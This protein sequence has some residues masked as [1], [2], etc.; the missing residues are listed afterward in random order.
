MEN[1]LRP[2]SIVVENCKGIEGG[3]LRFQK[4]PPGK[5]Q[6]IKLISENGHGKTSF[7]LAIDGLFS[8]GFHPEL[9]RDGAEKFRAA[10]ILSD[11]TELERT[12]TRKGH[13]PKVTRPE[14]AELPKGMGIETYF[15]SLASG[16]GFDPIQFITKKDKRQE[17]LTKVMPMDF[18]EAEVVAAG[19][20][21]LKLL[22]PPN[23]PAVKGLDINGI[24]ALI[25]DL[26]TK[27]GNIGSR[28]DEKASSVET[29]RKSLLRVDQ[30][31][32][33][34]DWKKELAL[35][36]A[37]KAAIEKEERED[38][39][40]IENQIKG[41]RNRLETIIRALDD[42]AQS[43]FAALLK[44]AREGAREDDIEGGL[45][46]KLADAM[47]MLSTN[48]RVLADTLR[49]AQT[50]ID[51]IRAE[52]SEAMQEMAT[53]IAA[54]KAGAE[55]QI[56]DFG[57][58]EE[59]E[60]LRKEVKA[61]SKDWDSVAAAIKALEEL[62]RSK[63]KGLPVDGLEVLDGEVWFH[64]RKFDD[65]NK[66][67]QIMYSLKIAAVGA[68]D[69]GLLIGDEFEA[70]GPANMKLLEEGVIESGLTLVVTRVATPDEVNQYGPGLRSEPAQALVMA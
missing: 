5:G 57:I 69:L 13:Y 17:F 55:S 23:G 38:V 25:R 4:M 63:L 48:V 41:E 14:G 24:N 58:R 10:A 26:T 27:R 52:N 19:G 62:R 21:G 22:A 66:G 29:F 8:G 9:I 33:P 64:G 61:L 39:S 67:E 30:G 56:K 18:G 3:E 43:M 11:G 32:E 46:D 40:H 53:S 20:P 47:V 54:A 12:I 36:E 60:R 16:M 59:M 31:D 35:L 49:D 37:N 1:E 7:V 45:P 42:R 51:K 65:W 28:R 2:L 34:R 70:L 50:A 68:G 6:L 15:K 44:L